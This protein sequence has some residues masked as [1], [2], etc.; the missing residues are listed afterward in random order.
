M[1]GWSG[2]GDWISQHICKSRPTDPD[3]DDDDDDCH[4]TLDFF[5]W[6]TLCDG[7]QRNKALKEVDGREAL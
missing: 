4:S 5:V 6:G 7:F 1:A 3:D 2:D